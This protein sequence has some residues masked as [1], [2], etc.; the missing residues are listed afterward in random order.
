MEQINLPCFV[1]YCT[2]STESECL[3]NNVLAT[4]YK[5]AYSD[6]KKGYIG[7]LI[8]VSQDILYGPFIATEPIKFV[9]SSE[10][11]GGK[12]P[13]QVKV[14]P[15]GEV[16]KINNATT[17]LS[18]FLKIKYLP[19][20]NLRFLE[21]G[22]YG[23]EITEKI[24]GL[25]YEKSSDF[26]KLL[27]SENINTQLIQ[28]TFDKEPSVSLDQVAGLKEIKDFI[29]KRIIE[30]YQDV[31]YAEILGLRVGGGILLFGPP[32][33]GKTLI[34]EAISNHIEA[35]FY[36]INPSIIVGFPGEAEKK[37]ELIFNFLRREPRAILFLDEAEWILCRRDNLTSSVMQRVIPTLLA[38]VSQIFKDRKKPVVIIA[39]TNKPHL[40]DPA[41]LRSGRF[42]KVF[43]VPLPDFESRKEILKIHLSNRACENDLLED[44]QLSLLSRKLNGFSGADILG[45][46][47]EAAYFAFERRNYGDAIITFDDLSEAISNFKP[48]VNSDDVKTIEQWGI[49]RGYI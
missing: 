43:Y 35:K 20:K 14:K 5:W 38:Q 39:A 41:F 25:L 19:D 4:N 44:K 15:I 7:F 27:T 21:H 29:K 30:P 8:N 34:A 36:E 24:I 22:T 49:E 37:I 47:E 11:F 40:I 31:K 6:L 9:Q 3:A 2:N 23:S 28:Q 10:L 42:D 46:I 45:I 17:L 12:F 18:R 48:S 33:T 32:G 1:M 26:Y 13:Y 16:K